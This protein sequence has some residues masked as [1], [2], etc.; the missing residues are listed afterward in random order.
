MGFLAWGSLGFAVFFFYSLHLM[1]HA[2]NFPG[3][4][5]FAFSPFHLFAFSLPNNLFSSCCFP[6]RIIYYIRVIQFRSNQMN[7]Y[8]ENLTSQHQVTASAQSVR[9]E[10]EEARQN[11]YVIEREVPD[12]GNLTQEQLRGI[13]QTSNGVLDQMGNDIKWLHSYV[14]G[15]KIYC[16][17]TATDEEL[18]R[19]HARRGGFPANSVTRVSN[20]ID[21]STGN[22]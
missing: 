10:V 3:P 11:L 5:P 1:S 21:P 16:V 18:V 8:M 17:Y 22:N 14:A 15:N 19:E 20:V 6:L 13:S 2:W 12:A 7:F 4:H 9:R